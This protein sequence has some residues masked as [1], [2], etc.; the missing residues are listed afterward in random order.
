MG[1]FGYT[2]PLTW[3]TDEVLLTLNADGIVLGVSST[4]HNYN[5]YNTS[6]LAELSQLCN[7]GVMRSIALGST[8]ALCS[9]HCPVNM[10][11]QPVMVPVGRIALG[12]IFKVT[13]TVIDGHASL[14]PTDVHGNIRSV[15]LLTDKHTQY[16][17]TNGTVHSNS[18]TTSVQGDARTRHWHV[19]DSSNASI[20]VE[21]ETS[22]MLYC[23]FGPL[24][25][26]K[27]LPTEAL[28]QYLY[29]YMVTS[30]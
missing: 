23:P 28:I 9:Y 14:A 19:F 8:D 29:G 25:H 18:S 21:S 3:Y 4:Y 2:N 13:G 27:Y 26:S 17:P 6:L 12:R 10:C 1:S 30:S 11:L 20:L 24:T 5:P 16:S 22:S 7:A 15:M